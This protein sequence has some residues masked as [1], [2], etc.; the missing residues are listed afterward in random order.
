MSLTCK[1][2][3][4]EFARQGTRGPVP[5]FCSARCKGK[6]DRL[7]P[8]RKQ[9]EREYRRAERASG[10]R[11]AY[12]KEYYQRP[13]VKERYR[14]R[15]YDPVY[16]EKALGQWRERYY[17]ANPRVEVA[18][19]YTGHIW[20]D[21]A[22]KVVRPD[23]DDSA[24]WADD[25]HDDMGEAVLALLEGRDMAEAVRAYR[26][27]EYVPRKLTIHY[28]DW[29]DD[30][31]VDRWFDRQMPTVPSAEDEYLDAEAVEYYTKTRFSNVSTKNRRMKHKT[32]TPSNRRSNNR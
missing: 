17:K 7:K 2:C 9:Y 10:K 27:Q 12:E 19:P 18:A 30:D 31:G 14:L 25:Y 26:K 6:R 4:A 16:R 29:R 24:P 32:S 8:G 1:I 28:G 5:Q 23:L 22:R 21:M 11:R 20:L 15:W 3:G 13:E